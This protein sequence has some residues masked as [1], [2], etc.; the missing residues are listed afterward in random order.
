MLGLVGACGKVCLQV[1]QIICGAYQTGH[2]RLVEANFLK[3]FLTLLV[4]VEFG[5]LALGLGGHY[6][7]S[8]AFVLDGLSHGIDIFVAVCRRSIVD[9][10]HIQHRL[11]S[12]QK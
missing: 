2:T 6:Q 4:C 9:I 12:Q 11:G 10:A 1:K 5:D 3:E 7:Q 8:A